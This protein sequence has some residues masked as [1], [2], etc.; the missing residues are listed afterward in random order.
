MEQNETPPCEVEQ[1]NMVLVAD[2]CIFV[3]ILFIT[4]YYI[5]YM[6]LLI[7]KKNL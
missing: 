3:S 6:Y 4:Y 1:Q 5:L 2:S 7:L